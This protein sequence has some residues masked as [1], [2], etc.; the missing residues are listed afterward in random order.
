[1]LHHVV[2]WSFKEGVPARE[3]DELVAAIRG[4]TQVPHVRQVAVGPNA[5]PA[6]AQGYT[7]VYWSLFDDMDALARY[8]QDPRH[9][10]V[11]ARLR[12]AA[13]KLIA[14]DLEV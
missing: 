5:S 6:R 12:D 3:R 13:E 14:V 8:Q 7:H 10:P 9:V 4:L 2:L 1:M 11:A